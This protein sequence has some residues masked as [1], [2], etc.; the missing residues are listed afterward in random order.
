ML[1]SR[2]VWPQPGL[3]EKGLSWLASEQIDPHHFPGYKMHR[4][5]GQ[6]VG[7]AAMLRSH[8]V[9]ETI[10][11]SSC[12]VPVDDPFSVGHLLPFKSL[13][14]VQPVRFRAPAVVSTLFRTF[15]LRCDLGRLLG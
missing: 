13:R 14:V 12:G 11:I 10:G 8:T 6:D 7:S 4:R 5:P 2:P 15:D 3:R 1:Q 9:V